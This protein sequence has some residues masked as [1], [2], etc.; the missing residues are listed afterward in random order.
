VPRLSYLT[1]L[2]QGLMT[3][4]LAK[5]GKME[6]CRRLDIVSRIG[7]SLVFF[8]ITLET[9]VLYNPRTKIIEN[10]KL[11]FDYFDK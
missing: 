9:L 7:F 3:S 5:Q 8:F 1:S 6:Q 2:V 4:A 10:Q 11:Q